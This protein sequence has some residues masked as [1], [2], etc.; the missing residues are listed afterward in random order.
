MKN[1]SHSRRKTIYHYLGFFI[2]NFSRSSFNRF[3]VSSFACFMFVAFSSMALAHSIVQ[4]EVEVTGTI[5][6]EL[7]MP[8]IGVTVI[9]KG[10][11]N[12]TQTDFDGNFSIEIPA[13]ATLTFSFV[14][15]TTREI[16]NV[17]EDMVP[18]ELTMETDVSSLDEVVIVGYGEQKKES[19][20]AA[21][22]QMK[23]EEVLQTGAT[24]NV[25]ES[26]QGMM[27][28]LT[29]TNSDGLPGKGAHDITI[30]GVGTWQNSYPL[31]IVDGIERS[32]NSVDPNEIATI[33][34]LKDASATAVY[35]V[36]GANGV[37]MITTKRG[38]TGDPKI[39]FSSNFGF[40]RPTKVQQNTD[41]ITT[42]MLYNEAAANDRL[43]GN[44]IPESEINAWRNNLQNA[45]P[46]NP[47]FPQVD[48]WDVLLKD[49]GFQQQYNLNVRGGTE[50]MKYFGS[51]GYV[52]EGDI[53]ETHKNSDYNP[54]FSYK[55]YNWR[56]NLDFDITKSTTFSIN[57]AGNFRN[58]FQPAFGP[59]DSSVFS[60]LRTLPTNVFPIKYPDGEWGDS[61]SGGQN[62][63]TTLDESG[64]ETHKAY[65][66]FYDA[67]LKQKL[68]FI[69]KG[70]SVEGKLA[71]T[72]SSDYYTEKVRE[73]N[74]NKSLG[75]PVRYYREYDITKPIQNSDGTISYPLV[76]EIRWPS[77][78]FQ[79]GK[80]VQASYDEFRGYSR[81]LFYQF[82]TNYK[83]K[84][85]KH[86]VS[87]L[88][89]MNRQTEINTGASAAFD[90]PS[91]REDWVGRVTY[92]YNDRYLLEV[93]G[94]YTGSEKFAAGK[95]FGFFPSFAVGWV[96]SEESFI[97]NITGDVLDFLKVRY[98]EGEMG[99][100]LGAPRFAY[101]QI[102]TTGGNVPFGY[103]NRTNYGPLYYE[104]RAANPD[105]TW[106]TSTKRDLG[107]ELELFDKFS[108]TLD[109]YDEK[110]DGIL[111]TR[112]TVPVWF[113]NDVASGNIGSTKNRGYELQIG[114]QD[115]IGENF[116]YNIGAN[117]SQF[118]NRIN[119]YDDPRGQDQYLK[120]AGKPIRWDRQAPRLINSGYYQSLDDIYNQAPAFVGTQQSDLIPGD[121]M[122]VDYNADG[123][124]DSQDNVAME[125]QL[126]PR[127]VYGFNFGFDYKNFSF[128][129]IFYGVSQ[130]GRT[131]GYALLW[132]FQNGELLAHPD[133]VNRWT[134]ETATT[135]EK[136]ALH[137]GS[138]I[139]HNTT[140]STYQFV[141]G[142]YF[143][144]KSAEIS[145]KV[146]PNIGNL[147]I[148]N[149]Q[150]YV[151]GNNLWTWVKNDTKLDPEAFGGSTYPVVKRYNLGLRLTF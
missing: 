136:P 77:D 16:E 107:I 151:N 9:E 128:N 46:Y 85:G 141:D 67:K 145:Y 108:A 74:V 106:E 102:Y 6:D 68:N 44:I 51:L 34:I 109:L 60:N 79:G 19:V 83:R 75:G 116:R 71:F 47:Y 42:M 14:G 144:L 39:N 104:G 101:T 139:A 12:G 65:Q 122:F 93:N 112:R 115:N 125:F 8:M 73:T 7:G 35:G 138:N 92:A 4:E 38:R 130:V 40:K 5:V 13:G 63:V 129:S 113:G 17:T 111:M 99:S 133:V 70:L 114:W 28:G 123:I 118:E 89:L 33:S 49:F 97:K 96:L 119:F 52:N 64:Q 21:I 58:R 94:A 120:H 80:P 54:E 143:R 1:Y 90:F 149:L 87:A 15:Y 98:S 72:S 127:T 59:G 25:T 24:T 53:F 11:S 31:T 148:Q 69:T 76:S 50:T 56:F 137:L 66:G 78:N 88:A 10:T 32:F 131:I 84:F 36:R 26:L 146:S 150:I 41:F 147:D 105:Q 132:D 2:S 23:G 134:P 126:Y 95:R 124:V 55:R 30:R 110:R 3:I 61:P 82:S 117:L 45:G 121:L 81:R 37:I 22:S 140:A 100:D 142:D 27:P 86:N 135:A 62:Y 91:Y 29:V 48:W 103:N 43:W 57:F 18:L 20:V